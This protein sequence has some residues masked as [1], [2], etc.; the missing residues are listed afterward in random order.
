MQFLQ[1]WTT[2][3][4]SFYIRKRYLS[5][6]WELK[7]I[8][9]LPMPK[10]LKVVRQK[11]GLPSYYHKFIPAY[12]DLIRPLTQLTHKTVWITRPNQCKKHLTY[13]KKLWRVQLQSTHILIDHTHYLLMHLNVMVYSITSR[14]YNLKGGWNGQ[15]AASYY[16]CQ[17]FIA[18]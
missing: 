15:L 18:R 10:T 9:D 13:W 7:S 12:A 8:G 1:I 5:T 14:V 6:T 4:R 3:F 11:L 17:Q 16:L 2:L